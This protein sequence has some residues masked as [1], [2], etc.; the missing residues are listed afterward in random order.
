M[1]T[2]V[3]INLQGLLT[4]VSI[5]VNICFLVA[6]FS[7]PS[8]TLPDEYQYLPCKETQEKLLKTETNNFI[9]AEFQKAVSEIQMRVDDQSRWFQ[10]KFLFAGGLLTA[11][12]G[13]FPYAHIKTG[14]CGD[15]GW[16]SSEVVLNR[17]LNSNALSFSI[18]A[19]C[20]LSLMIDLYIRCN[21]IVINQI[22]IWIS[23]FVE[24][25]YYNDYWYNQGD[26]VLWEKFLRIKN[27]AHAGGGMHSDIINSV[28]FFLPI[29][30]LTIFCFIIY[31]V[32]VSELQENSIRINVLAFWGVHS[33]LI[34]FAWTGHYLPSIFQAEIPLMGLRRG[35]FA[36]APYVVLALVLTIINWLFIFRLQ[37]NKNSRANK[38]FSRNKS[39][40]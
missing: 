17:V 24:P 8:I 29:H 39:S 33:C 23:S 13:L 6:V 31:I 20:I 7:F 14:S 38:G 21:A 27:G 32:S 37:K 22:G 1:S 12:F 5:V 10:Y 9:S 2:G 4:T 3:S 40:Q 16:K 26:F 11:F 19:I 35:I 28:T 25:I 34:V 36:A 15:N 30:I 18:A